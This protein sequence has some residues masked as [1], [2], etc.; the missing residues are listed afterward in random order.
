MEKNDF[1]YADFLLSPL[2]QYI[3]TWS[4][5]STTPNES[6]LILDI[7]KSKN[8]FE[9]QL[10]IRFLSRL[11]GP[12]TML[13]AFYVDTIKTKKHSF[14][15][16]CYYYKYWK[17]NTEMMNIHNLKTDL[18]ALNICQETKING[19]SALSAIMLAPDVSFPERQKFI[20]KLIEHNF[21][22]TFNDIQLAKLI[23]YDEILKEEQITMLKIKFMHLLNSYEP[24]TW[25]IFPKEV[26]ELIANYMIQATKKEKNY[27]LLPDC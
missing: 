11:N 22:P 26:K 19:Y 23:F 12:T 4:S 8:T 10:P 7:R 14:L 20:Q 5:L 9:N 1:D 24:T 25:S 21:K 6:K 27:W 16:Y 17:N 15:Q 13:L 2:S 18:T 3:P